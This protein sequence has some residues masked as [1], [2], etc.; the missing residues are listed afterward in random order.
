[1][2]MNLITIGASGAAA[3]RAGL[4]LSAQNVANA[5]NPDYVRRTLNQTEL[6]GTGIIDFDAKSALSGARAGQV[7]RAASELVQARAR[8][9]GADL[10]RV[11][12]E[13]EGLRESETALEKA[14]VFE[15]L[16]AF[17]AALTALE[18]DPTDPA[19]R[20]NALETARQV[21]HTFQF[22]DAALERTRGNLETE[23]LARVDEVNTGARELARINVELVAAREGTPGR[24]ALLDARDATLRDLSREIGVAVTFDRFGAAQ[25]RVDGTPSRVLV[26]GANASNFAATVNPGGTVELLLGGT[27]FSARTGAMA[28]RASAIA[29]VIRL[30][31]ELDAIAASTIARA[32]GAQG[33]GAALDGSSGQPL[34]AGSD[35]GTIAVALND[36][37]GLALASAGSPAGSRDTANLANLIGAIA[38]DAGPIAGTDRSL[39]A[40]SSRIAGLDTTREGLSVIEGSARADLLETTGVDLDAEAATLIRLQQAFE[41]NSRVIQVATDIFDT[42]LGLR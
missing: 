40:L 2:P 23:T 35:A 18:A 22:A 28:G 1:M 29:E 7:Q 36:G 25:V 5:S 38:D 6:V 32:N 8:D 27:P 14:K 15:T 11:E 30:Q 17:E 37:S 13:L 31:N 26:D 34:F 24:A 16:V 4:E 10:A 3:A 9:A 42:I 21:T 41:A 19:L 39:A 20:T 12:A 33:S